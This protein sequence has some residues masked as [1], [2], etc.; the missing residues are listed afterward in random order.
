MNT[1]VNYIEP[2]K[3]H[4]P[5]LKKRETEMDFALWIIGNHLDFDS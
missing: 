5:V 2:T 3:K 4:F 1:G